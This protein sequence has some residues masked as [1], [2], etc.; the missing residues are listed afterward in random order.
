MAATKRD[1]GPHFKGG[2]RKTDM[3]AKAPEK[4]KVFKRLNRTVNLAEAI[5][6]A[7]DPVL[8]KRG[9]ASKDIVTHWAAIAPT[10]Y[11][12]VAVP[13]RLAWPR[14]ERSA[15]GATLYLRC[16]PG[17]ALALAHEGPRIAGAV[18]RYFGYVLVGQV[19]LSLETFTPHSAEVAQKASVPG[20]AEAQK[21]E[22]A[23][24]TVDDDGL[25]EALRRLGHGIMRRER[26]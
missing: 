21:I 24:E 11:D 26:D 23:I 9:F 7:L 3:A 8:K 16:A 4:D 18:N 12:A 6:D 1:D 10:P 20:R 5:N 17:H 14:G 19:R 15:E 13:D 25:R 2:Q 22:T